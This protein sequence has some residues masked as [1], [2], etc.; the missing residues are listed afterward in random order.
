MAG[1]PVRLGACRPG[2]PVVQVRVR[3][4]LFLSCPSLVS[5]KNKRPMERG[6]AT[7]SPVPARPARGGEGGQ[8]WRRPGA[9]HVHDPAT[10]GILSP[11]AA[12]W[13][14]ACHF[15]VKEAFATATPCSFFF[16]SFPKRVRPY[17]LVAPER[18]NFRAVVEKTTP[19]PFA[20]L[21]QVPPVFNIASLPRVLRV[22]VSSRQ[23]PRRPP[24][25]RPEPGHPSTLPT[26][27]L[28][29]TKSPCGPVTTTTS[30]PEIPSPSR[31]PLVPGPDPGATNWSPAIPSHPTPPSRP[32]ALPLHPKQL[33]HPLSGRLDSR[34]NLTVLLYPGTQWRPRHRTADLLP[35][36]YLCR[37]P[38]PIPIR[39]AAASDQTARDASSRRHLR[40]QRLRRLLHAR[41]HCARSPT[42]RPLHIP[43]P[44]PS[45][46]YAR[47]LRPTRSGDRVNAP[48]IADAAPPKAILGTRP[49]PCPSPSLIDSSL[50]G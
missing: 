25:P 26:G 29:G 34:R 18:R 14:S 32:L 42:V 46:A 10:A 11:T 17:K 2:L 48:W 47:M 12:L 31:F 44:C 4:C 24:S 28:G 49:Q 22:F 16:V 50:P 8:P 41:S 3:S 21:D 9:K 15:I 5:S 20:S 6:G 38:I 39:P 40:A 23:H 35:C 19:I 27:L 7:F 43:C 13:K 45:T 36:F 1:L 37:I 30:V 33:P